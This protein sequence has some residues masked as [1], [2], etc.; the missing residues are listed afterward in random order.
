[1]LRRL[2]FGFKG[3]GEALAMQNPAKAKAIIDRAQAGDAEAQRICIDCYCDMSQMIAQTAMQALRAASSGGNAD[4]DG[5][6]A[7]SFRRGEATGKPDPEAAMALNIRSVDRGS[8]VGAIN[9]AE[10]YAS[11][12]NVERDCRKTL[13]YIEIAEQRLAEQITNSEENSRKLVRFARKKIDLI[14]VLAIRQLGTEQ[15]GR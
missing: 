14:K 2:L 1:M 5:L 11:G 6:L 13:E 4:A 9:L 8:Y 3:F 12:E 7:E 10:E 15:R